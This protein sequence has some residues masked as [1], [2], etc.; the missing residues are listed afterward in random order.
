MRVVTFRLATLKIFD[1]SVLDDL[2]EDGWL[3]NSGNNNDGMDELADCFFRE[4]DIV[5]KSISN[6]HFDL[7]E[8][9]K[10]KNVVTWL[11]CKNKVLQN[12][13]TKKGRQTTKSEEESI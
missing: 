5:D 7:Y 13:A 2:P 4:L 9:Q 3:L 1:N 6:E 10:E 8:K 12:Q 11:N